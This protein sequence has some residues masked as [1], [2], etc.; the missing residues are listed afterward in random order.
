MNADALL[1]DTHTLQGDSVVFQEIGHHFRLLDPLGHMNVDVVKEKL[2]GVH[3]LYDGLT[4]KVHRVCLNTVE[5][6]CG[7]FGR[8]LDLGCP[9][10]LCHDGGC[11]TIIWSY[12]HER[13]FGSGIGMVVDDDI[14]IDA[15]KI[16]MVTRLGVK[17]GVPGKLGMID[18]FY[19]NQV[20]LEQPDHGQ[21]VRP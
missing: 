17:D 7:Q 19:W 4:L 10:V 21:V 18:L 2:E 9:K 8:G 12:V 11:R 3:V 20:E 14:K 13:S 15:L 1:S 6:R 5:E 16:H